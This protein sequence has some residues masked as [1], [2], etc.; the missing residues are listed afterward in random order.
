MLSR[1]SKI[2]TDGT[3]QQLILKD[4]EADL[5]RLADKLKLNAKDR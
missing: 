1:K 3:S 5:I 2:E 4:R